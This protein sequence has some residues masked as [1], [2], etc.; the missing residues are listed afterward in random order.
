MELAGLGPFLIS[1]LY[2]T[3]SL[4]V[5][6]VLIHHPESYIITFRSAWNKGIYNHRN[7]RYSACR[8]S[9][10]PDTPRCFMLSSAHT[11]FQAEPTFLHSP[12]VIV[13]PFNQ[14]SLIYITEL[15]AWHQSED[16][17]CE[18]P[19]PLCISAKL[20]G[21]YNR[22]ELLSSKQTWRKRAHFGVCVLKS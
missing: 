4:T 13:F 3:H 5:V 17:P 9:E 18:Q 21:F 12:S 6:S 14:A 7:Q 20:G 22:L 10:C 2:T 16:K 19:A 8:A 1:S 15:I 11:T